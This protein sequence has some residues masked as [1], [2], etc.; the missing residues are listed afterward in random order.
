MLVFYPEAKISILHHPIWRIV[1]LVGLIT[2][3]LGQ[4]ARSMA[5]IHASDN[6]SHVVQTH[7]SKSHRLVTEGIYY[8]LRHPS[9]FGFYYWA[10]GTQILLCNPISGLVFSGL[11]WKFFNERIEY[12]EEYLVDFFGTSYL[13]YRQI[14]PTLIPF[15][16]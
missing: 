5:M 4:T 13:K 9:Y 15:I 1:S 12:E 6:F 11:L 2:T 7:R 10:L 8:F 14:T 3:L 16:K